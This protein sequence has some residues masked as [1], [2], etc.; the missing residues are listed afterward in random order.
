MDHALRL[1]AVAGD[2]LKWTVLVTHTD[3][4]TVVHYYS[5]HFN[6]VTRFTAATVQCPKKRKLRRRGRVKIF[7][8]V[9]ICVAVYRLIH[10]F[11]YLTHATWPVEH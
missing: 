2:F 3:S 11:I 6:I 4:A 7:D 8:S 9:S 5:P 10:S 1:L